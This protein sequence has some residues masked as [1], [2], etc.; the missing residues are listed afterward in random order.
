MSHHQTRGRPGGHQIQHIGLQRSMRR[1]NLS[2]P[3]RRLGGRRLFPDQGTLQ[4]PKCLYMPSHGLWRKV[5]STGDRAAFYKGRKSASDPHDGSC[6]SRVLSFSKSSSSHACVLC[7]H[8]PTTAPSCLPSWGCVDSSPGKPPTYALWIVQ[9]THP[10][11]RL[12]NGEKDPSK[13]RSDSSSEYYAMVQEKRG[14]DVAGTTPPP[15]RSAPTKPCVDLA[16]SWTCWG[17]RVWGTL[18]SS[19][20]RISSRPEGVGTPTC[21]HVPAPMAQIIMMQPASTPLSRR[22]AHKPSIKGE[23]ALLLHENLA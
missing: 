8:R 22:Q 15:S 7:V 11:P 4:S 1:C 6:G 23:S 3:T 10:F 5:F 9:N 13:Q 20:C 2:P 18:A 21:S 16:K 17:V 12:S 19:A 14:S